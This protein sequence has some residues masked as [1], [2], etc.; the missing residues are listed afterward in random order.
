MVS[1]ALA[2]SA[3]S[4]ARSKGS[5]RPISHCLSASSVPSERRADSSSCSSRFA[6][7]GG[8]T[9]PIDSRK[10]E[11]APAKSQ[12]QVGT[13]LSCRE[14]GKSFERAANM[15]SGPKLAEPGQTVYQVRSGFGKV[16]RGEGNF[17]NLLE[18]LGQPFAIAD[19]LLERETLLE[20]GPGSAQ[21]AALKCRDA[22]VFERSS[23][24]PRI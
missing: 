11:A 18:G 19:L 21:I 9:M 14:L 7:D 20:S 5:V 6:S 23:D 22:E 2:S 13:A 1:Q 16:S 8:A 10:S 4:I 12:R 15:P 24:P 17:A 3:R